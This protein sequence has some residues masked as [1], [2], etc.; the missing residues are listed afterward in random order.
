MSSSAAAWDQNRLQRS[1][2]WK[3]HQ[4]KHVVLSQSPFVNLPTLFWINCSFRESKQQGSNILSFSLRLRR[5]VE[6]EKKKKTAIISVTSLSSAGKCVISACLQVWHT[7]SSSFRC[8]VCLQEAGRLP[9]TVTGCHRDGRERK[10]KKRKENG[11]REGGRKEK[12]RERERERGK[13]WSRKK[14]TTVCAILPEISD[15]L[16]AVVAVHVKKWAFTWVYN[17]DYITYTVASLYPRR[18]PSAPHWFT[19]S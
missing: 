16:N 14:S 4:V 7:C 11:E 2:L 13:G 1:G 6:K 3:T 19:H 9:A 17:R 8:N 10:K 12:G 15:W 18:L 5:G